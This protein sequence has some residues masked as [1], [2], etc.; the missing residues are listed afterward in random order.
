MYRPDDS[1]NTQNSPQKPPVGE[2][3]APP[4]Q[5]LSDLDKVIKEAQDRLSQKK[6]EFDF[7]SK[8][9]K[10][11]VSKYVLGADPETIP[12]ILRKEPYLKEDDRILSPGPGSPGF[13]EKENIPS[14]KNW[15]NLPDRKAN[16]IELNKYMEKVKDDF[17]APITTERVKELH[18][19]LKKEKAKFSLA[20]IR[21]DDA[22]L[23][24]RYENKYGSML[25]D[26]LRQEAERRR[27]Q[28][29]LVEMHEM[30]MILNQKVDINHPK[31]WKK[32]GV[33]EAERKKVREIFDLKLLAK[34]DKSLQFEINPETDILK[35]IE[36]YMNSKY[37]DVHID[38]EVKAIIQEKEADDKAYIAKLAATKK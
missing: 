25:K 8:L 18:A 33:D 37:R 15:I 36:A 32:D 6:R 21:E 38:K 29:Y 17:Y 26:Q 4:G 34:E 28:K 30:S 3:A 19:K 10:K 12:N 35:R 1:F 9:D 24:E 11:Q 23:N 14:N 27:R 2:T 5:T 31:I 7:I 13:L 16:V 22:K 20:D